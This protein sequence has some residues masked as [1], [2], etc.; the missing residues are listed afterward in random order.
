VS[1]RPATG[2]ENRT[3]WVTGASS[4]VGAAVARTFARGGAH[5]VVSAQ[6]EE[7][8]RALADEMAAEGHTVTARPLDVADHAAVAVAAGAILSARG[9]IHILVNCAGINVPRRRWEDMDMAEWQRVVAVNLNGVANTTAAVLPAMRARHDGLIVNISSWAGR[10]KYPRAGVAYSAAKSGVLELSHSVNREEQRHNIRC[11]CICPTEIA[12]EILLQRPVPPTEA[13]RA[14]M[15][16]PEDLADLVA[17]VAAAPARLCFNEIIF[18][19]S[20]NQAIAG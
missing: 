10:H 2:S 9:A 20:P 16:Q 5:V 1:E 3:V 13:E 18:S 11:C 12:T 14:G 4:G 7:K 6:R 19:S 15:L 17:Y 8:L